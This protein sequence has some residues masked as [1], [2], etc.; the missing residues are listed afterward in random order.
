M[1]LRLIQD[2]DKFIA[3]TRVLSNDENE[4]IRFF[5]KHKKRLRL[6]GL[7]LDLLREHSKVRQIDTPLLFPSKI[8]PQQ[9]IE[10][11]KSWLNALAKAQIDNFH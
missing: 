7:A 6:S 10:L 1:S 9:P 11:K 8:K 2:N 3:F 4:C 5:D